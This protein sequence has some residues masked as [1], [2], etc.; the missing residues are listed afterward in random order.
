MRRDKHGEEEEEA[1]WSTKVPLAVECQNYIP[2]VTRISQKDAF[3]T[4]QI[5]GAFT[6]IGS[7][8]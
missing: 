2:Q 3:Y 5:K 8:K 7:R 6:F 4:K 1:L